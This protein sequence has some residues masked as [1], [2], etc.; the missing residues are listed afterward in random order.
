MFFSVI[1]GVKLPEDDRLVPQNR[2][3]VTVAVED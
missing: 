3:V 1:L 2:C